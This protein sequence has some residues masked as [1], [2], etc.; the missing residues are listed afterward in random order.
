M[1]KKY[2]IEPGE[3]SNADRAPSVDF[4][5]ND[6]ASM[7]TKHDPP[8]KVR[9]CFDG[10]DGPKTCWLSGRK[11]WALCELM[12]AGAVGVTSIECPA[13]RL[14]AYI[15]SLRA[16]GLSIETIRERHGGTYPGNH[17]RYLLLSRVTVTETVTAAAM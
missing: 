5:L 13:P 15:F 2:R 12:K 10:P 3:R 9:V 16:L 6:N 14:G 7:L 4:G 1:M 17:A 11:L 8:R